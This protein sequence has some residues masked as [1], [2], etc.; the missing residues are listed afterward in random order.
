MKNNA[1]LTREEYHK[2]KQTNDKNKFEQKNSRLKKILNW[3]I[4]WLILGI[5][6]T[7]LILF[8]FNP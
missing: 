4:F 3:I 2:S 5:I 1:D 6:I 8:F 7:Y